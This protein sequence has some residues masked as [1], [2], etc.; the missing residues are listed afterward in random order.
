[1]LV[2]TFARLALFVALAAAPDRA[3]AQTSFFSEDL[4]VAIGIGLAGPPSLLVVGMAI[5]DTVS[6]AQGTPFAPALAIGDL[7]TGGLVSIGAVIFLGVAINAA[8]TSSATDPVAFGV[9]GAIGLAL[10]VYEIAHGIWSLTTD[11]EAQAPPP[12]VLV[13]IPLRDGLALAAGGSF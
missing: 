10:G 13:P 9:S 11:G 3:S 5:A 4:G 12:I 2:R 6:F 8:A 7:V 1:M